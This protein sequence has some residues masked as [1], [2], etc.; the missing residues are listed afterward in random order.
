MKNPLTVAEAH[1]SW[2]APSPGLRPKRRK[3]RRR[4]RSPKEATNAS[5]IVQP[6]AESSGTILCHLCKF[7]VDPRRMHPHM[8]RFHGAT[9][10]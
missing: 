10:H 2:R 7:P 6:I 1:D 3:A 4:S 8:V 9:M 5:R